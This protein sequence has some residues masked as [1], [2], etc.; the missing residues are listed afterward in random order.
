MARIRLDD[1]MQAFNFWV[2]DIDPD[3]V[4]PF[5]ALAPS[6]GFQ[7]CSQIDLSVQHNEYRPLDQMHAV[8]MPESASVAPIT[9]RR[10]ALVGVSDFYDWVEAH[11]FGLARTRRNLLV[12]HFLGYGVDMP[13]GLQAIAASIGAPFAEVVRPPGRAWILWD[14]VPTRYSSGELDATSGE[15]VI[16]ELELQPEAVTQIDLTL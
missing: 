6:L 7:A 14:C 5:F 11:E 12:V 10:G 4:P 3:L 9:L 13:P 8:H 15:V 2:V 16:H 1:Y